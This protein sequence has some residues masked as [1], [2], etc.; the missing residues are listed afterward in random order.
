MRLCLFANIGIMIFS[1]LISYL[2]LF[3]EKPVTLN[4]QIDDRSVLS[5]EGSTN[6]TDFRCGCKDK[7]SKASLTADFNK[8][9]KHVDFQNA[10][11][12]IRTTALD[13]NNR[14]MNKDLYT[15]L[16]AE[17]HPQIKVEI[18]NAIPKSSIKEFEQNKAYDYT[19]VTIITIAGKAMA[20]V[21]DV[22][23]SKVG[24][25]A[26]KLKSTK[27]ISMSEYGITPKSP[28]RLI[29]IDDKVDINFELIVKLN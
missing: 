16:K 15:S 4:Y 11:L 18:I 27:K 28:I 17:T 2:L 12:N 10:Q 7:F 6:I 25:N 8:Y 20:Q 21:L 29:K 19:A 13:C 5:L 23:I 22:K 9:S 14:L 1:I 24:Q 3:V 26:F